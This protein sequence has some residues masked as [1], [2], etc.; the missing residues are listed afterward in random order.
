LLAFSRRQIMQTRQVNLN[1]IV[2]SLTKMLQR[3]LGKDVRLLLN[4]HPGVLPTRAD[5]G[6]L[7]QV[8]L[9]FIVNARDAMPD[10][11]QLTIETG[12]RTFTEAETSALPDTLPGRY[13]CLRVTDTGCGIAP[14]NLPRIFEPFFTTKEPGKGTGLGLATVFGIVKQH[15][16]SVAVES[17]VG[18][19]T[20]FQVFLPA[21]E[22]AIASAD[23]ITAKPNPRG[24]TETILLV[25]DEPGVRLLLR[26]MLEKHGYQVLEAAH[27]VEALRIWEHYSG[28]IHLLLT[29]IVMPEGISGRELAARLLQRAPQLRVIFI[30]GYSADIAGRELVLQEGQNFLQKPCLADHILETVRKSL[31]G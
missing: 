26:T 29:D 18:R 6:L 12:E 22:G 9:N 1:E 15:N 25:E 4:L 10:G 27:G 8:L 24:G 20:T 5:P 21:T 13:V 23:E 2:T 28:P 16:G 30:S 17:E 31:D 3:I 7:D 14:E 11:G 19:G